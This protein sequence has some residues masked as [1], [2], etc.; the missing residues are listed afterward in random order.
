MNVTGM[1]AGLDHKHAY[2][3]AR[4]PLGWFALALLTVRVV[5]WTWRVVKG[6]LMFY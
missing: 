2:A 4:Q 3:G 5:R 1:E 6:P